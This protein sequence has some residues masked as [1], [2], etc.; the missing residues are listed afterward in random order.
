MGSGPS[1][2]QQQ[3]VSYD[4]VYVFVCLF[5]EQPSVVFFVVPIN[6]LAGT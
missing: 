4:F 6:F 1:K 2:R 5:I 3:P